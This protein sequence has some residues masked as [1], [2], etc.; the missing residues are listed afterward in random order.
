M[1]GDEAAALIGSESDFRM[2][3]AH[4]RIPWGASQ[5]NTCTKLGHGGFDLG[6]MTLIGTDRPVPLF[7]AVFAAEC[8][9]E[10]GQGTL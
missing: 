3:N 4:T 6:Q 10:P 7:N 2:S 1:S 5:A 8:C 9:A